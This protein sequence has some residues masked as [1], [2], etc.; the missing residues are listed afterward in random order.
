MFVKVLREKT[1]HFVSVRYI[2]K[3]TIG[4][5]PEFLSYHS[6]LRIM[7]LRREFQNPVPLKSS[8]RN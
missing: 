2:K 5:E 8:G 4:Q 7:D 6:H 1:T 3:G